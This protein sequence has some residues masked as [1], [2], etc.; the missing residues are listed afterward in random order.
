MAASALLSAA[1]DEFR[2]R[3]CCRFSSPDAR[4]ARP[5]EPSGARLQALFW[6]GAIAAW[7]GPRCSA[8]LAVSGEPVHGQQEAQLVPG[9]SHAGCL[10]AAYFKRPTWGGRRCRLALHSLPE[11]VASVFRGSSTCRV[12]PFCRLTLGCMASGIICRARR[13]TVVHPCWFRSL[14]SRRWLSW[15]RPASPS[16]RD[17]DFSAKLRWKGSAGVP[18]LAPSVMTSVGNAV[19]Q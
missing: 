19:H 15:R 5:C 7:L 17:V 2:Q 16:G 12:M 9:R 13:A 10:P 1:A 3:C 6:S 18:G 11:E 14:R 4:G 8:K